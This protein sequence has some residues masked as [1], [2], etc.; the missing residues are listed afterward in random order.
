VPEHWE[1]KR[2]RFVTEI[3]D[4]DRGSEYPN[5]ADLIDE[6]IPFLSSKNLTNGKIDFIGVKY[7]SSEKFSKLGQGKLKNGDLVVTVRGTIGNTALFYSEEFKTG[8]INAQMMIIRNFKKKLFFK[9]LWLYTL[10]KYWP[11]HL[12]FLAYGSAQQQLSNAVLS[13]VFIPLPPLPEQQ[14]IA[15]FL[16][17]ETAKIDTLSTKVNTVIER[18]KEYR[19]AII[20]SAVTGKIDVR[21]SV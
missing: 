2:L 1:V 10:S 7:I 13:N 15:D 8:F 3:I 4:G 6:G 20:S 12:D 19:T 9:F 18:L 11:I 16:D 21:G 5:D 17:R 14:A